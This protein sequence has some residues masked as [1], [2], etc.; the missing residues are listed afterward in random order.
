VYASWGLDPPS[1]DWVRQ[2]YRLRFAIETTY[3]QMHQARIRTSTRDPLLR[4]LY[5]G[6]ALV[7]RDVWVWFHLRV[8]ARPRRGGRAIDLEMLRFRTMLLWLQ[9]VA[10][11]TLGTRDT[12][13]A[14]LR[15]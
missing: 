14:Y 3:R 15:L 1:F 11:A 6:V 8:L 9:H 5:V 10:E 7:L 12:T 13:T 4:L 2:V